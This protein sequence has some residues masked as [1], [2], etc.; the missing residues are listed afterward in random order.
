MTNTFVIIG[1]DKY[2][3]L[4]FE[5]YF[6]LFWLRLVRLKVVLVSP[7]FFKNLRDI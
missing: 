1:I 4:K 7:K 5:K 6:F 2:I 3:Y